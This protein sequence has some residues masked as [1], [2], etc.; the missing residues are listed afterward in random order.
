[1]CCANRGR[2]TRFPRS[3]YRI[4][5]GDAAARANSRTLARAVGRVAAHDA[6]RSDA[7]ARNRCGLSERP[8][9]DAGRKNGDRE[10][11]AGTP[12]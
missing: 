7:P 12:G 1:M 3:S 6:D 9:E 10:P 5:R 8:I 11:R 2:V 4:E